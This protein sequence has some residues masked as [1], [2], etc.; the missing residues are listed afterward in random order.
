MHTLGN[1]ARCPHSR[2]STHV[3]DSM[4]DEISYRTK[5]EWREVIAKYEQH[6][7]IDIALQDSPDFDLALCFVNTS[8]ETLILP[9]SNKSKKAEWLSLY[10][11]NGEQRSV[12]TSAIRVNF[13]ASEPVYPM[14]EPGAGFVYQLTGH[15][16][17]DHLVFP[18]CKYAL[19]P[20]ASYRLYFRH[21]QL[22]SNTLDW[23]YAGG[24]DEVL[25]YGNRCH[26]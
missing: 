7:R 12:A 23:R 2:V 25:N 11:M 17:K 20:N 13:G 14:V 26:Y 21:I 18:A 3:K 8:D 4:D 15:Y 5:P 1:S 24:T 9:F 16:E 22:Q 6:F 10:I 19:Q